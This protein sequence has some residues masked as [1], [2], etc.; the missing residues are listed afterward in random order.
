V[1]WGIKRLLGKTYTELKERGELGP[2]FV[3]DPAGQ[4]KGQCLIVVAEKSYTRCSSAPRYSK[5]SGWTRKGR[6]GKYRF[7][8]VS[9]PAYFDPLR[10]TPVIEAAARRLPPRQFTIPG[11]VAAALGVQMEI[12]VKPRNVWYSTWRGDARRDDGLP[13]P[14]IPTCPTNSNSRS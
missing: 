12:T 1:V 6:P 9:V 3:P 2:F 5:R 4:K 11:P 13:V 7:G 8:V 14:T 10:V